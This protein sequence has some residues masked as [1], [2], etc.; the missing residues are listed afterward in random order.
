MA[1][2]LFGLQLSLSSFQNGDLNKSHFSQAHVK[3][4]H[5]TLGPVAYIH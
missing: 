5:I 3:F 2:I 1:F 4:L